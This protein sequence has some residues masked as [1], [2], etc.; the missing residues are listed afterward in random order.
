MSLSFRRAIALGALPALLLTACGGDDDHHGSTGSTVAVSADAVVIDIDA[1]AADPG[2]ATVAKGSTVSLQITSA[3]EHEFHL[4]GYDIEN[5]GT[6][7]TITF[8]ADEAGEFVV[9]NHDTEATIF[10][11]VVE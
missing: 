10:T 11:L 5:R 3:E 4:H 8:V 7:V 6:E 1:D 2:E 9:E